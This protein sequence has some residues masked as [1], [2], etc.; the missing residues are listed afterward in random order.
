PITDRVL[1]R[2]AVKT[3]SRSGFGVNPVT[4]RDVDDLNRQMARGH[5]QF[6]ASDTV[7]WLVTGENYTQRDASSPPKPRAESYT[8]APRLASPGGGGYAAEP[9]DLASEF[10]PESV[11]DTWSATSTLD[12]QLGDRLAFRNIT[13][14]REYEGY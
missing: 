12:W 2:L 4:G 13:N 11:T 10:D 3:D 6:L 9:R 14:Y 7:T 5:L 1:G 8:D